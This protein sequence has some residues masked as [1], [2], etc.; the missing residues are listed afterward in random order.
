MFTLETPNLINV[1]EIKTE[2]EREMVR[3]DDVTFTRGL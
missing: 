3:E 2:R 1:D